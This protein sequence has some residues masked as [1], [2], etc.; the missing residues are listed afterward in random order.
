MLSLLGVLWIQLQDLSTLNDISAVFK[1]HPMVKTSFTDLRAR[2][3]FVSIDP[4]KLFVLTLTFCHLR[5]NGQHCGIAKLFVYV[6]KNVIITYESEVLSVSEETHD[7]ILNMEYYRY[8]QE[9]VNA[10]NNKLDFLL[11]ELCNYG[12]PF[13]LYNL[14]IEGLRLQDQLVEFCSRSISFHKQLVDKVQNDI[15]NSFIFRKVRILE[16]SLVLIKSQIVTSVN[17]IDR[18][19][20][21]SGKNVR[22]ESNN[23]LKNDEQLNY[24]TDPYLNYA[25]DAYYYV[26]DTIIR[27]V[28]EVQGLHS[29]MESLSQ[30]VTA[31]IALLLSLYF[32]LFVPLNFL[33]GIFG[34]NFQAN[35]DETYSIG[36]LNDPNGVYYFW[37]L[38]LLILTMTLSLLV[39]G[40]LMKPLDSIRHYINKLNNLCGTSYDRIQQEK[41]DANREDEN[42]VRV[43]SALLEEAVR[44]N[45]RNSFSRRTLT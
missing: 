39:Y 8:D 2:S 44:G 17:A 31:R 32:S 6:S 25:L 28:D 15:N 14:A 40:G 30:L 23:E 45:K 29:D 21:G 35:D 10:I 38:C 43:K 5:T 1:L 18:C 4:N 36:I 20:G 24:R 16:S 33:T 9:I 12:T 41:D 22:Y 26:E 13:L 27:K 34:M 37:L 11:P 7:D 3:T 42:R 19:M